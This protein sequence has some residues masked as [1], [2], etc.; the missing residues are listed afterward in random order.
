[1]IVFKKSAHFPAYEV[2]I[3]EQFVM[4]SDNLFVNL[5]VV[6]PEVAVKARHV[7]AGIFGFVKI[8]LKF[9]EANVWVCRVVELTEVNQRR[10]GFQWFLE[11]LDQASPKNT[12]RRVVVVQFSVVFFVPNRFQSNR[13]DTNPKKKRPPYQKC[14][15]QNKCILQRFRNHFNREVTNAKFGK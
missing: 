10:I 1:M 9:Y 15:N 14:D 4:K 8:T 13:L 11:F 3:F 2:R 6:I 12:K 5:F 7:L